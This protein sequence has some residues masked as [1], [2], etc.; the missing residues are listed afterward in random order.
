MCS[1]KPPSWEEIAIEDAYQE[2]LSRHKDWLKCEFL[3]VAIWSAV[4]SELGLSEP[5]TPWEQV[6]E[7]LGLTSHYDSIRWFEAMWDKLCKLETETHNTKRHR[8]TGDR[9]PLENYL[10]T[11]DIINI[12]C[13]GHTDRGA[14]PAM[15]GR[16]MEKVQRA[17]TMV[18]QD[19]FFDQNQGKEM[20]EG[21]SDSFV[22]IAVI[23][24]LCNIEMHRLLARRADS[25]VGDTENRC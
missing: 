17:A 19:D 15:L 4:L 11:S 2:A 16:I 24:K 8:Y 14:L 18:G 1:P 23:S 6:E 22:D 12:A 9:D 10:K 25:L 7:E 5:G 20:N 3:K 13:A 21:L